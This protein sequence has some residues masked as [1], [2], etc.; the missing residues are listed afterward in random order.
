LRFCFRSATLHAVALRNSKQKEPNP[1]QTT[2]SPQMQTTASPQMQTTASPQ[3]QTTASPQQMQ[4][5]ASANPMEAT[6]T[7][8][9]V[10]PLS[11]P[12]DPELAVTLT[13]MMPPGQEPLKLFRTVAH[14]R[15]ILDKLRST[16]AY[17]LNFGT[18]APLDREL[19]I[20][21]TCAR[22]DCEYEWGVHAAV[23]GPIVGLTDAQLAATVHGSSDD[24]VWSER[25][26]LLVELADQLHDTATVS[27]R[28]W[29]ALAEHYSD[30]QLVEL[31]AIAGQYHA[32]SYF[33]NA[34]G[35]GLEG[36]ARRFPDA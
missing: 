34:L 8:Q 14:N 3:M 5:T 6:A 22:C 11:P 36:A 32:V 24:P 4:T 12:Y 18:V 19:V 23:F 31:L 2:A 16:G 30:E 21:R 29:G 10:A 20:H 9:R 27:E 25:Q 15:H 17:L 35:V 1:M 26:A 13:R 7:A 28:L 33:A